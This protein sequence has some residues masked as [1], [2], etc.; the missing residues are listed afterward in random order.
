[1]VGGA[2]TLPPVF[3]ACF[4][5]PCCTWALS[6]AYTGA[7]HHHLVAAGQY[8]DLGLDSVLYEGFIGVC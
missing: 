6:K 8:A 2:C 5:F 1:M 3:T 7:Y 4:C